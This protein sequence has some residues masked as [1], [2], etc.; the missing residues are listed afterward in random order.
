MTIDYARINKFTMPM[1]INILS[2]LLGLSI[3]VIFY[4]ASQLG[5]LPNVAPHRVKNRKKMSKN[6]LKR[7][8]YGS[9]TLAAPI[10]NY[11]DVRLL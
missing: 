3:L 7:T 9:V 6:N 11:H 1:L 2:F 4:P 8:K 10:M 5:G